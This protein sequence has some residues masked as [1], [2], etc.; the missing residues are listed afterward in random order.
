MSNLASATDWREEEVFLVAERAHLLYLQG[1]LQEAATLFEG[2]RAI[3]PQNRYCA[4]A[5]AV[6]YT[7][8][9]DDETRI[10]RC[11]GL[12]ECGRLDEARNEWRSLWRR[13]RDP[14]LSRLSLRLGVPAL[15]NR[16]PSR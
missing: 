4:N 7:H 15:E 14:R 16:Y 12:I 3:D 13:R 6:I 9:G 8:P 5:L 1:R 10:C 2:L 11:E